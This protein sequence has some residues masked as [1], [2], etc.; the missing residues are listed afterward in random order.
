ML[1][2]FLGIVSPHRLADVRRMNGKIF[3]LKGL[4]SFPPLAPFYHSLLREFHL[5]VLGLSLCP[6]THPFAL[7]SK[8]VQSFLPHFLNLVF[9]R[10]IKRDEVTF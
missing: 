9:L 7:T 8:E 3:N 4:H 6:S 1:V 5:V 10:G 2:I